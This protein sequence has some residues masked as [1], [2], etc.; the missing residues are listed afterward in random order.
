[1]SMP[2]TELLAWLRSLPPDAEVG[3]DEGGLCL[4]VVDNEDQY[5]EIGGLPDDRQTCPDCLDNPGRTSIGPVS[6]TKP[7]KTC[8]GTGYVDEA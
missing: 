5:C 8:K 3:V 7:C 2:I 6:A 4:R 1:M